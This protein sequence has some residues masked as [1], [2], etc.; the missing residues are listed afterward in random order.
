MLGIFVLCSFFFSCL[1][2]GAYFIKLMCTL[3]C[4]TLCVGVCL[5][6]VSCIKAL[7]DFCTLCVCLAP[8]EDYVQK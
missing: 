6:V 2:H 4:T 8:L 5:G 7:E 1:D 3:G